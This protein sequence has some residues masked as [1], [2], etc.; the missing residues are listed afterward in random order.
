MESIYVDA[1]RT[2]SKQ[3]VELMVHHLQLAAMYFEA[4]PLNTEK[5]ITKCLE[6]IRDED[7][8]SARAS[9]AFLRALDKYFIELGRNKYQYDK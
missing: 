2:T 7:S 5:I 3:A 6:L 4:A 8:P 9:I 1:P